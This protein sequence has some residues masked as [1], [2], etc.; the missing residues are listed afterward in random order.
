M[1]EVGRV[2]RISSLFVQAA[3]LFSQ[4]VNYIYS[5]ERCRASPPFFSA[6]SRP[7]FFCAKCTKTRADFLR[8]GKS[9]RS[10][11]LT[12]NLYLEAFFA[13]GEARPVGEAI[14]VREREQSPNAEGMKSAGMLPTGGRTWKKGERKGTAARLGERQRN[15]ERGRERRR[16][17]T[18]RGA[19]RR[20]RG[21]KC[22]S[23][24]REKIAVERAKAGAFA[25]RNGKSPACR[26]MPLFLTVSG[27][28]PSKGDHFPR[29]SR[30]IAPPRNFP[31][32]ADRVSAFSLPVCPRFRPSPL[33]SPALPILS[34]AS[35]ILV[36]FLLIAPPARR[37]PGALHSFGVWTL[38]PLSY[39][40]CP[41]DQARSGATNFEILKFT[42]VAY[43]PHYVV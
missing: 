37:V 34:S 21:N 4:S 26:Q 28:N 2:G 29:F 43:P 13:P 5:L 22:E 30:R 41:A 12:K 19:P 9:P 25:R 3:P 24:P 15:R 11:D 42:L 39:F 35:P 32:V 16:G 7:A 33:L 18:I 1:Y 8:H 40:D 14:Q 38:F 17:V 27:V 31:P 20:R 6:R 23:A 36:C 10:R